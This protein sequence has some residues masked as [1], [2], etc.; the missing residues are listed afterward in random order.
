MR[1]IIRQCKYCPR[2]KDCSLAFLYRADINTGLSPLMKNIAVTMNCPEYKKLFRGGDRV[3]VK[4]YDQV[5]SNIRPKYGSDY[6]QPEWE[7]LGDFEGI[8]VGVTEQANSLLEDIKEEMPSYYK[9]QY[10]EVPEH[11]E[12]FVSRGKFYLVKLDNPIKVQ[13]VT[14]ENCE[15]DVTVTYI[16]KLA[17]DIIKLSEVE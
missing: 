10:Q 9:S 11:D 14:K 7:C 16:K 12:P 2:G 15:K 17:K 4:M 5:L 6:L 1:L 13:R 3:K 8:I